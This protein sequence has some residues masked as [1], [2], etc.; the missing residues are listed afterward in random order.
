MSWGTGRVDQRSFFKGA[1]SWAVPEK[2]GRAGAIACLAIE[3]NPLCR[4]VLGRNLHLDENA[5]SDTDAI[6]ERER[7]VRQC[8]SRPGYIHA[9]KTGDERGAPHVWPCREVLLPARS[10]SSSEFRTEWNPEIEAKAIASSVVRTC[11][12]LA[13]SPTEISSYVLLSINPRF[14]QIPSPLKCRPMSSL[15]AIVCPASAV[16]SDCNHYAG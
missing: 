16:Q 14:I 11:S 10:M 5:I 12:V 2:I 6:M 4:I 1:M 3:C 15:H 7:Y 8:A 9:E 13:V